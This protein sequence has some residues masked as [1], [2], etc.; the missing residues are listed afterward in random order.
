MFC[1]T[2]DKHYGFYFIGRYGMSRDIAI[3]IQD[4][5]KIRRENKFYIDKSLFIKEWWENGDD[6][7]LINRPRRFGKTLNMNMLDCFFSVDHKD[8][9][10][11]FEDLNIW[12]DEKYWL[13]QGTYPVIFLSFANVKE[14]NFENTKKK[15]YGIISS[16]YNDKRYILDKDEFSNDERKYYSS[17]NR[18][19]EETDATDAIHMLSKFLNRYY[20]K[21]VIIILDEYD[22]PM[23][24]AYINGYWDEA[25]QFFRSFF[26]ATFKTN[27]YMERA[28]IT[29]I[30]RISK[31]SLFSDFN[32]PEVVTTTSEKYA[33]AFG[34]T[35]DEVFAAMD[36]FGFDDKDGM[37][38]WYDGFT[39]GSTKYI[40]NP[41]SVINAIDK[42]KF[43][44]YWA[45]TSSNGLAS[46][47]LREA[48]EDVK[49]QLERLINNESIECVIDEEIDYSQLDGDSDA[50]WSLL[51]ASGYLKVVRV[52]RD[53]EGIDED[54][55]EELGLADTV[56]ELKLTNLEIRKMM[57]NLIK[58]WFKTI[59]VEYN[60]F[61][62]ALLLDDVTSMNEFMNEI[63]MNSFSSFDTGK[64]ASERDVPERFYHGFVLGLM[65]ELS[66]R[67]EIKSNRES[68]FGRYDIMLKPKNVAID[69]AYI[70][71]FKVKKQYEKSLA[72]TLKNAH[73]Q[74]E[75]KHYEQE[76][77]SYGIPLEN[78]K[79]Y[80]FA[81]EGKNVL[82]G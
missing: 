49:K 40:Y 71:E 66:K 31:E 54:D 81:F 50:I 48:D 44:T 79:R 56:Y 11:L 70:I 36:E 32:N 25:V 27:P 73:A 60:N 78:I 24:E 59:K 76:L 42:R 69:Q 29:G 8:C 64:S 62:K 68:G 26:N 9:C 51:L 57:R 13:L 53:D 10:D 34:F 37:K 6:V 19:M 58:G 2:K 61:I 63:A 55:I 65:V 23:Q 20:G 38:A 41:W 22:T 14:K 43:A 21:N 45:N 30:T 12:K 82:I 74:I 72:E 28:I 1:Y 33:T 46:K 77:I 17:I 5:A 52:Y 3:G 47:L 35:Q 67:Y 7:T 16:V 39:F 15:I 80:G 4:F 75:E 18:E